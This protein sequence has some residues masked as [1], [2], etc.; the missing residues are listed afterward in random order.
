MKNEDYLDKH[1]KDNQELRDAVTRILE[2]TGNDISREGLLDTPDRVARMWRELF[3]G[4]QQDPSE[5]LS[6]TFETESDSMV[7]VKDIPFHSVCEHHLIPFRGVAHVGYIPGEIRKGTYRIVGLSKFARLVD[8][9]ARRPQVQENLT[10]QVA[11]AIERQLKP[12]GVIVVMKA[13]HLCMSMRGV[14]KPGS[15]TVTSSV[16]GLF[17]KNTDDVKGEFFR[18]LDI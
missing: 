13:E 1:N 18:M 7:V 5:P 9:F 10:S 14:R 2:I 4:L 16:T 3:Q 12:Q 6:T 8:I 17:S 15:S 11:D